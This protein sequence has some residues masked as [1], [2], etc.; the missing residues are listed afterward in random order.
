MKI[1]PITVT[2]KGHK[3][4]PDKQCVVSA[5]VPHDYLMVMESSGG[6]P[7]LYVSTK[8]NSQCGYT[9]AIEPG[10]NCVGSRSHFKSAQEVAEYVAANYDEYLTRC[11]QVALPISQSYIDQFGTG[12]E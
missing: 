9:T 1:T 11:K 8:H 6:C 12:M 10:G 7:P 4:C 5:M 2:L 3:Y